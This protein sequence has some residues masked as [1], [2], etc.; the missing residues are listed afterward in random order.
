MLLSFIKLCLLTWLINNVAMLFVVGYLS[1]DVIG[2][3]DS[4]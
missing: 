4:K 2:Y 1:L 3:E